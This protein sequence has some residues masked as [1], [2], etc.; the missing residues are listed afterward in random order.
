MNNTQT[1]PTLNMNTLEHWLGRQG[2]FCLLDW[3]LAESLLP[4][5]EYE[6]WRYAQRPYL[7]DA[8]E[9]DSET[10]SAL[11]ASTRKSANALGLQAAPQIYYGWQ[12]Q[13]ESELRLAADKDLAQQLGQ[14]WQRPQDLMQPDLFMDGGSVIC[15][16]QLIDALASRDWESAGQH[17]QQMSKLNASHPNLG[18]YQDLLNYS[19]HMQ[20]NTH[21]SSEQLDIEW[22]GLQQEIVGLARELMRAKARDY[23]AMAWR[24]V[25][26]N[27]SE[28]AFDCARPHLHRGIALAQIPDWQAAYEALHN[29]TQCF[30]QPSLLAALIECATQLKRRELSLLLWCTYFETFPGE[31]E[32][33]IQQSNDYIATLWEQFWLYNEAWDRTFFPAYLLLRQAGLIHQLNMIPAL[34][35]EVTNAVIALLQIKHNGG[36][37][38]SARQ[39]LQSHSN[40]LLQMYLQSNR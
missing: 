35:S 26:D 30:Q 37:E 3:L 2:R 32:N 14:H 17:L 39:S 1:T 10:L 33:S 27:L 11:L 15:E 23:L 20:T 25:A 38:I 4:Y 31:A 21:I 13:T 34:K 16:N 19:R 29:E 40:E 22:Q 8:I 18:G 28:Q 36:D 5:G 6:R 12:Q 24:R 9:L 7:I